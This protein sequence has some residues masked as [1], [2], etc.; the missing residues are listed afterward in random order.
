VAAP[1]SGVPLKGGP[2]FE[3]TSWRGRDGESL[4][5]VWCDR[6]TLAK[7]ADGWPGRAHFW[8][9]VVSRCSLG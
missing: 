7:E 2:G 5:C 9:Q 6:P 8:R 3:N 4:H 1:R